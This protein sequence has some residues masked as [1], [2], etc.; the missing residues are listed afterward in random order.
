MKL[1]FEN[2][3]LRSNNLLLTNGKDLIFDSLIN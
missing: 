1:A 2:I 3:K